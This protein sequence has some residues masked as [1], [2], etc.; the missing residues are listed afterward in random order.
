MQPVSEYF[1]EEIIVSNRMTPRRYHIFCKDFGTNVVRTARQ[2][3]MG[4]VKRVG[5]NCI[6]NP[7]VSKALKLAK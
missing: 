3:L 2:K 5:V 1:T 6:S 7:H 4:C